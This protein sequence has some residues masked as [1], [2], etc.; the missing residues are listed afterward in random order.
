MDAKIRSRETKRLRLQKILADHAVGVEEPKCPGQDYGLSSGTDNSEAFVIVI[1]TYKRVGKLEKI[2]N[3]LSQFGMGG[4]LSQNFLIDIIITQTCDMDDPDSVTAVEKLIHRVN[5]KVGE[6]RVAPFRSIKHVKVSLMK[7]DDSYSTDKKM[8]GNKR[9]SLQNLKNGLSVALAR[10]PGAKDYFVLEDDA[11]VSCDVFEIIKFVRAKQQGWGSKEQ[12]DDMES[13]N[14]VGGSMNGEKR[15]FLSNGVTSRAS[16]AAMITLDILYRPSLYVGNFVE[17]TSEY[18]LPSSEKRLNL[19]HVN[20]RTVIKT[21]AYVLKHKTAHQYVAA[22][23]TVDTDADSFDQGGYFF[24][25]PFCAPYCYDHVLEWML[26]NQYIIAPDIPR[27]TQLA[28]KGMTYKENPL[29]P[30]YQKVVRQSNFYVSNYKHIGVSYFPII[31][32]SALTRSRGYFALA[33]QTTSQVWF[34]LLFACVSVIVCCL[35]FY[36]NRYNSQRKWGRK[37][38]S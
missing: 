34:W 33:T 25:C 38:R 24:G 18:V 11:V 9:N 8:Y 22:L 3:F 28:G 29:T 31:G 19:I 4:S 15:E 2:L 5:E 27:T 32:T 21:F 14:N 26:Q 10:H 35:K 7:F 37:K 13:S 30:I 6:G 23:D 16:D 1:M 17:D 36:N 20:P 12:Y